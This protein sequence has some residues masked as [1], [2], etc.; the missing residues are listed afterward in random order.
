MSKNETP[1]TRKYWKK[2]G[3]TLIEEF[4]MV[5]A[6]EKSGKRAADAVIVLNEHYKIENKR[7]VIVEG[8]DIILVQTKAKRLGMSLLGQAIISKHLVAEFCKPASIKTVVICTRGDQVLEEIVSKF[9]PW[10]EV[11]VISDTR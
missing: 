4:L 7:D 6:D 10:I 3:G 11:E 2:V 1:L 8:K 5:R 9:Y